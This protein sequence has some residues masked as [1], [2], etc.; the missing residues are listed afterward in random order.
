[1]TTLAFLDTETTSLRPDRRAWE[2][3]L[4][5]RRPGEQDEEHHWFIDLEDLDLPNADLFSLRIGGFYDRHPDAGPKQNGRSDYEAT[6]AVELEV[7]TR[8]AHIIGGVPN[9]DTEVL[10]GMLRRH[11]RCPA[12]HYHLQD[13]ETLIV[14]YLCGQGKPVPDLPWNSEALSRS[15]GVDPPSEVERHTALGD[16]R[17]AA[18]IWDAVTNP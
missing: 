10:D 18:R 9:F 17:W 6:V 15:I 8:G 4:I 1:M 12:W 3:G 11:N 14:G 7:L 13:A 2:V 5:L 16:A